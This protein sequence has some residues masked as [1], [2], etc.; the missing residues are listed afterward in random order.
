VFS[1]SILVVGNN[2]KLVELLLDLSLKLSLKFLN[3]L[4]AQLLGIEDSLIKVDVALTLLEF[5]LA[6][7]I[8]MLLLLLLFMGG[9]SSFLFILML[10]ELLDLLL[11]SHL[12]ESL[13]LSSLLNLL[14][15]LLVL[16]K[17]MSEVL[18]LQLSFGVLHMVLHLL[19]L[20]S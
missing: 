11:K 3:S 9:L 13:D 1:T 5:G 15:T 12:S 19:K 6:M 14:F 2:S 4:V 20:G 18:C 7:S 8:V 10:I 16:G 17:G